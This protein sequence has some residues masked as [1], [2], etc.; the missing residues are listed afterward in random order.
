M[1]SPFECSVL[2]PNKSLD[3]PEGFGLQAVDV[4]IDHFHGFVCENAQMI[5][6]LIRRFGVL[7]FPNTTLRESLENP[8][9]ALNK[10]QPFHFDGN[11]SELERSPWVVTHLMLDPRCRDLDGTQFVETRGFSRAMAKGLLENVYAFLSPD[12]YVHHQMDQYL[13]CID[14][15]EKLALQQRYREAYE[16]TKLSVT[17]SW[18]QYPQAS[19]LYASYHV[20]EG[21]RVAHGRLNPPLNRP[22]TTPRLK[23]YP[24]GRSFPFDFV[25]SSH[26]RT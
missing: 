7:I 17:H 2:N 18:R 23:A 21:R 8:I 3:F 4:P 26:V 10:F 6:K 5:F 25:P 24:L 9:S 22:A 19:V 20:S 11:G 12:S 16:R 13:S 15:Q 1:V 14:D